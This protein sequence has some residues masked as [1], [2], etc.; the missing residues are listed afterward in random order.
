MT[1]TGRAARHPNC[2]EKHNPGTGRSGRAGQYE[3]AAAGRGHH[4]GRNPRPAA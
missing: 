3:A 2:R 4:P 1:G